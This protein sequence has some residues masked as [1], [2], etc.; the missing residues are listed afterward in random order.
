MQMRG[1]DGRL[2]PSLAIALLVATAAGC[3]RSM[4]PSDQPGPERAPHSYRPPQGVVPD[5]ETAV[6]IAE[7]VLTPVYGAGRIEG[8]RPFRAVLSGDVWHVSGPPPGGGSA[9]G[10]VAEVEIARVDGRILRITHGR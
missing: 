1:R 7:A 10:G 8:E 5:G 2:A 3:T 9:V 6:R 4:E